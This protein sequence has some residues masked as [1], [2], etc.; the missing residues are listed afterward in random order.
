MVACEN[1]RFSS[2][3]AAGDFSRGGTFPHVPSGEERGEKDVFAGEENG[4]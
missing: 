2:L 1:I 3:S 4:S